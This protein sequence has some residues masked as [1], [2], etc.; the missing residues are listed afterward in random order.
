MKNLSA[1]IYPGSSAKMLLL[2]FFHHS[3]RLSEFYLKVWESIYIK[4]YQS[5]HCKQ[6][7]WLLCLNEISLLLYIYLVVILVTMHISHP[8]LSYGERG[9][10]NQLRCFFVV[11]CTLIFS[12]YGNV[13]VI[14]FV[15]TFF[16]I[17]LLVL[18]SLYFFSYY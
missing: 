16:V 18:T 1:I 7:E 6:K 14:F 5:F 15:K 4:S 11:F 17:F 3:S 9:S 10:T 2:H 12:L 13:N 8:P